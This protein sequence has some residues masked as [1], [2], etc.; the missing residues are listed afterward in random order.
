MV[1]IKTVRGSD[2]GTVEVAV[3]VD[4]TV[5]AVTLQRNAADPQMWEPAGDCFEAWV[6]RGLLDLVSSGSLSLDELSAATTQAASEA[7]Y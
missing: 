3:S 2:D 7:S 5:G 6:S 4:G 1:T